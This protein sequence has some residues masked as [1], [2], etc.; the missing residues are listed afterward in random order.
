MILEVLLMALL[1]VL[2]LF[3]SATKFIGRAIPS[4]KNGAVAGKTAARAVNAIAKVGGKA[5][6]SVKKATSTAVKTGLRTSV[7]VAQDTTKKVT[8]GG[9]FSNFKLIGKDSIAVRFLEWSDNWI[10]KR[11]IIGFPYRVGKNAAKS[12]GLGL[13]AAMFIGFMIWLIVVIAVALIVIWLA[14]MIFAPDKGR[15]FG[16]KLKFWKRKNGRGSGSWR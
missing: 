1:V 16:Q 11:K 8:G 15:N 14:L 3:G 13:I 10:E 5:A 7:N 2:L 6:S 12:L 4:L 9:I